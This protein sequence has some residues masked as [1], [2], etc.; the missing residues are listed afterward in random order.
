MSLKTVMNSSRGKITIAI[1]LG[2]GL[3][4]FFRKQ[5]KEKQCLDF[6]A[7]PVDKINGQIFQYNTKCFE[8]ESV[9]EKCDASKKQVSF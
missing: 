2:F 4:T 8:F 3:S 5:C 1:L 9:A 7:P 6:K